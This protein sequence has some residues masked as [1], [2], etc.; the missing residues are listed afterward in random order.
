MKLYSKIMKKENGIQLIFSW[1][2]ITN[3]GLRLLIRF[4]KT[5]PK[6]TCGHITDN[7]TNRLFWLP[8]LKLFCREVLKTTLPNGI[9]LKSLSQ[10]NSLPLKTE[11]HSVKIQILLIKFKRKRKLSFKEV[12]KHNLTE[13]T[14][15][16][17][18]V[19]HFNEIWEFKCG[20][21]VYAMYNTSNHSAV[22]LVLSKM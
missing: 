11:S 2:K 4:S 13:N 14:K 17:L 18:L 12:K 9:S 3:R 20:N 19:S 5:S 1:E 7:K 15:S 6:F 10:T 8:P 22:I 21:L 16:S